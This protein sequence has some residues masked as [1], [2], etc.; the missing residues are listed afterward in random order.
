[1]SLGERRVAALLD[2]CRVS[3]EYLP[4][5]AQGGLSVF[6]LAD[7]GVRVAYSATPYRSTPASSV[8]FVDS[9][10]LYPGWQKPFLRSIDP[11]LEGRLRDLQQGF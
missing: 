1:M 5:R 3:Y 8:I 6:D 10:S 4:A 7:Y 9:S 2:N 11:S